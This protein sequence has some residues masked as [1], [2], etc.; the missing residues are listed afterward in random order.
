MFAAPKSGPER[1]CGFRQLPLEIPGRASKELVTQAAEG[2]G[3]DG[4]GTHLCHQQ[5]SSTESTAGRAPPHRTGSLRGLQDGRPQLAAPGMATCAPLDTATT[6]APPLSLHRLRDTPQRVFCA[7]VGPRLFAVSSPTN[8]E[9][10]LLR[11]GPSAHTQGG[12]EAIYQMKAHSFSCG[13]TR[14][15]E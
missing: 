13:L 9:S 1:G 14:P 10:G 2:Q 7:E 4:D 12:R 3:H 8:P 6:T 11:A 5:P 15:A